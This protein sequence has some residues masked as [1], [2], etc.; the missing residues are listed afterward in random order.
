MG[1]TLSVDYGTT[2]TTA[3]LLRDGARPRAVPLGP[4][5]TMPSAVLLTSGGIQVGEAALRGRRSAPEYFLSSPKLLLGHDAVL[6]GQTEVDVSDL[7]A[8]TLRTVLDAARE[9]AG[10]SEP[11]RVILTHPQTWAAPRQKALEQAWRQTGAQAPVTLIS[12]PI[13]AVSWFAETD[14]L[15]SDA[16]VAVLDFGG[17]TCDVAVLHHHRTAAAP[18]EITAHAGLD[19]L[20]GVTIDH[21]FALWVRTQV[22]AQGLIDLDDALDERENLAALHALYDAVNAAKHRLADWEYADV[23]VTVGDVSTSVTVTINEFNQIVAAETE[24]ARALLERSLAAAGVAGKDLHG[25]YLTGGSSRLRWIHQ[26]AADL[27]EGRPAHLTDPHLVV[28]LGAHSATRMRVVERPDAGASRFITLRGLQ[29]NP[30]QARSLPLPPPLG[31]RL[32]SPAPAASARPSGPPRPA[33]RQA[34]SPSRR[35]DLPPPR[36]PDGTPPGT[37]QRIAASPRP[38]TGVVDTLIVGHSALRRAV[39][40][41]PEL[42]SVLQQPAV[43]VALLAVPGLLDQVARHPALMT[44]ASTDGAPRRFSAPDDPESALLPARIFFAGSS[45]WRRAGEDP[46]WRDAFVAAQTGGPPWAYALTRQWGQLDEAGRARASADPNWRIPVAAAPPWIEHTRGR[47]VVTVP[48]PSAVSSAAA[49]AGFQEPR[50]AG[51]AQQDLMA[52]L[53]A[54]GAFDQGEAFRERLNAARDPRLP[55]R[56]DTVPTLL[57]RFSDTFD[58]YLFG[59]GRHRGGPGSPDRELPPYVLL[60]PSRHRRTTLPLL[61][62]TRDLVDSVVGMPGP[63][64][65]IGT[66]RVVLML[67]RDVG[68]VA[69]PSGPQIELTSRDPS[70]GVEIARTLDRPWLPR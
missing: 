63:P 23:P 1:W 60:V 34:P 68:S 32:A 58:L 55:L 50:P 52:V 5:D 15:P 12:E 28:A 19:D 14:S 53:R 11:D 35:I 8:R 26:M 46:S 41:S 17:G 54:R 30:N 70:L 18:L 65:D 4:E 43:L 7:V 59:G 2:N 57:G 31:G 45:A 39:E 62:V 13:A 40:E 51:S 33:P 16:H 25:L 36:S 20:G 66:R 24:R 27:L 61:A 6:L 22:R 69:A 10:G 64:G 56:R 21:V 38:A 3:A 49:G 48:A 37:E 42:A 29:A 44:V 47:Y 67:T 9:S